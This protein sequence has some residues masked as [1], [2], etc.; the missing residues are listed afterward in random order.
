M[1]T[2]GSR[3][4]IEDPVAIR[5][6]FSDSEMNRVADKKLIE[7]EMNETDMREKYTS[8]FKEWHEIINLI[9]AINQQRVLTNSGVLSEFSEKVNDRSNGD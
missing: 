4:T 2:T 9:L 1:S 5:C 3:I 7:N 8:Y 6:L